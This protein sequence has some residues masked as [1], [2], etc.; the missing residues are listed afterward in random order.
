MSEEEEGEAR[1]DLLQGIQVDVDGDLSSQFVWKVLQDLP[2]IHSFLVGPQKVKPL[3]NS[4][5]QVFSYLHMEQNVRGT[6]KVPVGPS[7][8]FAD[9]TLE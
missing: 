6:P 4:L 2:L 1:T 9:V 3:D 7:I 8:N 5:L